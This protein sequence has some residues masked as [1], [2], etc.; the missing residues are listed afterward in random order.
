MDIERLTVR[1]KAELDRI[2]KQ[3]ALLEKEI[4]RLD[5][6]NA[7]LKE[8]YHA[9]EQLQRISRELDMLDRLDDAETSTKEG[10]AS[11]YET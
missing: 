5:S 1:I 6:E 10:S 2:E 7:R 4:S 11:S 8:G 9:I 3:R